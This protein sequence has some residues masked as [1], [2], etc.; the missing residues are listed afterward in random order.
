MS[1]ANRIAHAMYRCRTDYVS[2]VICILSM[3]DVKNS[4]V[5]HEGPV[6]VTVQWHCMSLSNA[7]LAHS[8][9]LPSFPAF[10]LA[11]QHLPLTT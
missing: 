8:L 7:P 6:A 4:S 3:V 1:T 11:K 2:A 5:S 9:V 10:Q